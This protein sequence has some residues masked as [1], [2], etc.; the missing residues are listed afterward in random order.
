MKPF[1][2]TKTVR[3][4]AWIS[5]ALVSSSIAIEAPA[6]NA[7]PPALPEGQTAP[8]PEIKR[9]TQPGITI[10]AIPKDAPFLGVV[11]GMVPEMLADH[12]KLKPG[13]GVIIR[14]LVPDGP[15]SKAGLTINDVITRVAG[16]PVNSPQELSETIAEHQPGDTLAIDLIHQGSPSTKELTLGVRPAD[17]AALQSLDPL[18]LD[19]LPQDLAERIRKAI[20]GN[21]G[22]LDLLGGAGGQALPDMDEAIRQLKKRMEQEI[23]AIPAPAAPAAG[24]IHAEATVKFND[25]DGSIEVKS[26]D[27]GKVVTARDPNGNITWSGPWDTEQDKAAAPANVR[28]RVDSLNMDPNFK[29][30][31]LRFQMNPPIPEK[32]EN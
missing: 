4:G 26:K 12:L 5:T 2:F 23:G 22:Q 27:G 16:K 24:K 31:G 25:R 30:G 17:L 7:P 29:G 13:T 10:P 3:V 28:S 20:E 32:E 21:I 15:A 11:S 6:D 9:D 1:T 14:S 19:A 18:T 8:L